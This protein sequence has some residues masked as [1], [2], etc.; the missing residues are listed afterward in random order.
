MARVGGRGCRRRLVSGLVNLSPVRTRFRQLPGPA[1]ALAEGIV[2]VVVAVCLALFI[3]SFF[4]QAFYVP[5]GSMYPTLQ[6]GN[7]VK[8]DRILVEKPSYWFGGPSRGDIVVFK[9]P[10]GWL[11]AE[12]SST[13]TGGLTGVLST[14]GLFP[15]G[16]HLV[17]RVIGI[18]GDTIVCCDKSTGDLIINGHLLDGSGFL[19]PRGGSGSQMYAYQC[20]GAEAFNP[21]AQPCQTG[22]TVKVPAGTLFVMGDNRSNSKDS[23][24]HL[25]PPTGESHQQQRPLVTSCGGTTAFVP[26]DDVVGKVVAI[27]WPANRFKFLSRPDAF[28]SIR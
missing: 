25:C 4:V 1:R 13:P 19:A 28:A 14:I 2:L 21:G 24:A 11:T 26:I 18:G 5:S 7:G 16:G 3:K 10:G 22:W 27:L 6:G 8:S 17:K 23:A 15:G 12:E 20:D 9:D